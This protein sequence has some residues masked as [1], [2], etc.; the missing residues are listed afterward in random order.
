VLGNNAR[1]DRTADFFRQ[2]R[3]RR[4]VGL[5]RNHVHTSSIVCRA[6]LRNR[7]EDCG[8]VNGGGESDTIRIPFIQTGNASAGPDRPRYTPLPTTLGD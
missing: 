5:G 8:S 4:S 6:G 7:G 1:L 2:F 3:N